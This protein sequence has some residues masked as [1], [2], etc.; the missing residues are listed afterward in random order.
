MA[1]LFR[2]SIAL[3][4]LIV[5]SGSER[6][7]LDFCTIW[8]RNLNCL[9]TT[10]LSIH[11]KLV[12]DSFAISQ[13]T[14]PLHLNLRLVNENVSGSIRRDNKPKTGKSEQGVSVIS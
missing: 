6:R 11:V 12:L 3:V 5:G 4:R 2:I 14:K 13:R 1:N 10:R 8:A 7:P 9:A